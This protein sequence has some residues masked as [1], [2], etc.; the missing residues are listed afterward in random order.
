MRSCAC[1]R[2]RQQ[3]SKFQLSAQH[4][5]VL[6]SMI[7]YALSSTLIPS[8]P[9]ALARTGSRLCIVRA[10]PVVCCTRLMHMYV[11]IYSRADTSFA[12]RHAGADVINSAC[13]HAL[14]RMM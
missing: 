8:L 5:I 9:R 10:L 3:S 4:T 13:A 2:A 1:S 14:A 6:E 11:H 7:Y 12:Q